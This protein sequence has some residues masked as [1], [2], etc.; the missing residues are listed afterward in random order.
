MCP[1]GRRKPVAKALASLPRSIPLRA[2]R[3]KD[4]Q[5]STP[6]AVRVVGVA[7]VATAEL[8]SLARIRAEPAR[9]AALQA[10][11]KA[12]RGMGLRRVVQAGA[13]G[14][15]RVAAVDT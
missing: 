12:K 3:I 5:S 9:S 2:S 15:P 7:R 8:V 11:A 10:E 6:K 14:G 1:A 13:G 4:V